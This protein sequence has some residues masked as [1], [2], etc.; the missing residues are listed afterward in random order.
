MW[1]ILPTSII[2]LQHVEHYDHINCWIAI[3]GFKKKKIGTQIW[4]GSWMNDQKT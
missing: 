1:N 4:M 3:C 2:V